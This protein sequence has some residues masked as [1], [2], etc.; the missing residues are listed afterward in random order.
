MSPRTERGLLAIGLLLVSGMLLV[1]LGDMD[2]FSHMAVGRWAL[3]HHTVPTTDPFAYSSAGPFRYTEI[4]ADVSLYG[5]ERIFGMTGLSLFQVV[6]GFTILALVVARAR[7]TSPARLFVASLVLAAAFSAMALKPQVFSYVMFAAVLL[8]LERAPAHAPKRLLWLPLAFFAWANLHRAGIFGLAILGATAFAWFIARDRRKHAAYLAAATALSA[9]AMLVN[10]GGVYYFTSA[11]DVVNR[12]SFHHLIAEW[13]PLTLDVVLSRHLALVPLLALAFAGRFCTPRRVDA[14]LL[15]LLITLALATRGARLLPFVAIAAAPPAVRAI[16]SFFTLAAQH[17][18]PIFAS[19]LAVVLALA[20]PIVSYVNEVPPAYRGVGVCETILPVD[21]SVFLAAHRPPA[22]LFHPFN[23]GGYFVWALAPETPVLFDGRND[24]VYDDAL[25][26]DVID[27]ETSR[28]TFTR[29]DARFAFSVAT[30]RWANPN[31]RRGA[32]LAGDPSWVLVY[33][34]DL[35]TVYAHRTRAAA[36]A[37]ALGY[38]T[39][40]VRTAF[41]R[42]AGDTTDATFIDELRRNARE[43]PRSARAHALLAMNLEARGANAE[44]AAESDIVT[45]LAAEKGL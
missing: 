4:L 35:A 32:F 8:F 29:L 21:V 27:A 30:F 45:R 19:A 33:W 10:S 2:L 40:D 41:A 12:A 3:A 15:V 22:H 24:T 44:A 11:F 1:R 7:G 39:L 17:A 37:D 18:R 14:E 43:A 38:Q 42:A 20:L 28:A 31:E 25:F 13:Q 23:F 26:K 16:D 9:L 36:M 6:V 34:D 5:V